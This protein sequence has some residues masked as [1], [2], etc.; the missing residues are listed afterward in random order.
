MESI[1]IPPLV[2][3][4]EK[5]ELNVSNVGSTST[6][7]E[8]L[9]TVYHLRDSIFSD[10]LSKETDSDIIRDKIQILK[11][12]S[13]P[14]NLSLIPLTKDQLKKILVSAGTKL[15]SEHK[16]VLNLETDQDQLTILALFGV[17]PFNTI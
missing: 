4:D 1:H 7:A 12:L 16:L 8:R 3:S 15:R 6:P 17:P 14:D 13:I 5:Y 2:C 9:L 11:R 10:L